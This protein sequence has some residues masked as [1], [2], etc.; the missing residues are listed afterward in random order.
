[1]SHPAVIVRGMSKR[2]D[3][4]RE[5]IAA[6]VAAADASCADG[7]DAKAAVET[8]AAIERYAVAGKTIYMRRVA[9]TGVWAKQGDR[10]PE[11]WLARVSGTPIGEAAGTLET[12]ARLDELPA[13]E[14]ALRAG[15]LSR[16][17]ANEVTAAATADPDAE[18]R[19]LRDAKHQSVKTLRQECARVKAAARPDDV[20]HYLRVK[21][22]RQLRSWEDHDGAHLH[23]QS[24]P[25]DIATVLTAI[26]PYEREL[27]EAARKRD[28]H[29][30]FAA[31]AADALV[32]I[33]R[34]SLSGSASPGR[35]LPRA[36]LRLRVDLPAFERGTTEPGEVC[37]IP[38]IGPVPVVLARSVA[39]D[40]IIDL[41]VTQ[42]VDVKAIVSAGRTV[43]RAVQLALEERYPTCAKWDCDV[44][45]GL[46]NDHLTGFALTH[47]TRLEDLVRWC[48]DHHQLKTHRGYAPVRRADGHW[49]L[50]P[51]DRPPPADPS[52]PDAT[53][54]ELAL[55]V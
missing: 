53:D 19:L 4:V 22:E 49:D 21:R 16:I 40:A 34:D 3:A 45:H 46:E 28:E 17:Q 1:M 54:R 24:T 14:D 38:G 6:I 2:L 37:E 32:A 52:P 41:I 44:D 29:E 7:N 47:D 35:R 10:S 23:L 43:P 9:E 26:K 30:P 8:F 55:A 51:P 15:K 33:A 18:A 36:E 25:D 20:E 12:A 50:V 11:H 42:G 13:T 5:E 27:F 48:R 31:Y 39:S